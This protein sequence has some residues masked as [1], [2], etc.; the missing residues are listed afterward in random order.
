MILAHGTMAHHRVR[1]ARETMADDPMIPAHG[2]ANR[3]VLLANGTTVGDPKTP[4][5][6]AEANHPETPVRGTMANHPPVRPEGLAGWML[7]HWGDEATQ[8]LA[9]RLPRRAAQDG[10]QRPLS[11]CRSASTDDE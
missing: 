2:T 6:A 9:P 5:R 3:L 1:L 10:V 11:P 7:G 8:E 4:A